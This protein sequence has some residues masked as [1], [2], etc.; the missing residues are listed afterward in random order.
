[1]NGVK[2]V[3]AGVDWLTVRTDHHWTGG[4][5]LRLTWAILEEQTGNL[6]APREASLNGYHGWRAG[7]LGFMVKE[8]RSLLSLAGIMAQKYLKR[9]AEIEVTATRLDLA[10]DV[11]LFDAK[12]EAALRY[13]QLIREEQAGERTGYKSSLTL[14]TG[15]DSGSTLYLGKRA[16]RMFGRLYDKG[17]QSK[18]AHGGLLWR[19]EV[20]YKQDA[21]RSAFAG[22]LETERQRDYILRLVHRH[23][24]DRGVPPLFLALAPA[25]PLER[26]KEETTPIEQLDWLSRQVK[27]T[28]GRLRI[29]GYEEEVYNSLGLPVPAADKWKKE[30]D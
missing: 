28:I 24:R 1:M 25:K 14:I 8:E 19:Y 4:E 11:A 20:E 5:L 30:R 27:P 22:L 26:Y 18:T 29:A 7:P 21:A 3:T 9:V 2:E 16:G 12:P 10:V 13:A 15:S 23:F 6:P 17:I